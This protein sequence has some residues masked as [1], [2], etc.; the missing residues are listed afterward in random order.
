[1]NIVEIPSLG[2]IQ[3][4]KV[5]CWA[6]LVGDPIQKGEALLDFE[7]DKANVE[8]SSPASGVVRAIFTLEGETVP[9]GTVVALVGAD[10]EPFPDS[11][12]SGRQPVE[13]RQRCSEKRSTPTSF[14][15]PAGFIGVAFASFALGLSAN[16]FT[17]NWMIAV[18]LGLVLIASGFSL[19]MIFQRWRNK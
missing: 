5:L 2:D 1:M 7:T 8:I 14:E 19:G 12:K 4:G 13:V 6:K 3:E 10:D 15:T 18:A 11:L 17:G 16:W 9:I